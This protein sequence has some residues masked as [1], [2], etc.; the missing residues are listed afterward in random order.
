MNKIR[1]STLCLVGTGWLLALFA[2]APAQQRPPAGKSQPGK[3]QPAEGLSQVGEAVSPPRTTKDAKAKAPPA[4]SETI[5][6][7]PTKDAMRTA[8]KV[9]WTTANG[10]GLVV[11][12]AW[13]KKGPAEP[14]FQIL[15]DARLSEMFVP[16]HSG[17]PRFWDVSYNFSLIHLTPRDAGPFGHLV[18]TPPVVCREI[19]DRGIAW[20]DGTEGSRRGETMVLWSCLNAANYRYLIEYGFQ[21]DGTITFRVGSTGRNYGSREFEGHMHNGL[22]RVDVNLGGPDHNS[23]YVMEHLERPG[24][25]AAATTVHRPFHRGREGHE[26][27]DP[28]KF[29]MVSVRHAF[30]KNARGQPIAY[31]F[32]TPRMGNARHFGSDEECTQ[33]D[34][35]VTRNRKDEIYYQKLPEY[36]K[37][38]ESIKNSDVVVW[39]STAGH[40]EPRSEDGEMK[41]DTFTGVTPVMWCGFDL[42]P[43]DFWDRS[44][45][46]P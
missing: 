1:F 44:P 7:F 30:M 35:W 20:V 11:Q 10:F 43:R 25:A 42:K 2:G 39:L 23:A 31:D 16:Y 33:H 8:W 29:T 41:K 40:H 6:Q 26:D 4:A 17:S 36:V 24:E 13:F 18:G 21:D 34:F 12:G 27:W 15:G 14:W 22:W 38:R 37:N 46:Y 5:A 9:R 28:L 3:S 19:R 45:L 32:V